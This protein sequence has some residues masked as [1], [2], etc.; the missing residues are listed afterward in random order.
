MRRQGIRAVP[1]GTRPATR[2]NPAGLTRREQEVLA[3]ICADKSNSEISQHLVISMR[4]VDH[5]V[6]AVLGKLGVPSR[7]AAAA[8][9]RRHS[10]V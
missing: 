9:A 6:S 2:S 3:L 10:L 8:H 1:V 4:T 7:R 5:H